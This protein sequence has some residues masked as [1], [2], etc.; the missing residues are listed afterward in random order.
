M[1]N[2]VQKHFEQTQ[3][4]EIW[5]YGKKIHTCVKHF[6]KDLQTN[7]KKKTK[8]AEQKLLS[9][10]WL[11]QKNGKKL[12]IKNCKVIAFE[13]NL[14]CYIMKSYVWRFDVVLMIKFWMKYLDNI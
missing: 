9:A 12:N 4:R 2:S 7:S 10:F 6:E 11:L 5:T 1:K 8:R 3:K 14:C 13:K